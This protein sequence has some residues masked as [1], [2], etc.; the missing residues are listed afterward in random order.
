MIH[1][2]YEESL[3][4]HI[5]RLNRWIAESEALAARSTEIETRQ[6]VAGDLVRWRE[7]IAQQQLVIAEQE[8]ALQ[9]LKMMNG[10]VSLTLAG[11][12]I[13]FVSLILLGFLYSYYSGFVLSVFITVD[14]FF[15]ALCSF[16]FISSVLFRDAVAL[17]REPWRFS[18]RSL[19]VATTLIAIV[20][21]LLAFATRH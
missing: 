7:L 14:Y 1:R 12:V 10:I 15:V 9:R 13:G 3:V 17:G 4:R 18:L 5:E 21:G 6:M 19:L 2:A 16:A 11:V 8:R 20:L